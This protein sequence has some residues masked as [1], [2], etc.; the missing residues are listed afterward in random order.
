MNGNGPRIPEPRHHLEDRPGCR[1]WEP[2]MDAPP[3]L[4]GRYPGRLKRSREELEKEVETFVYMDDVSLGLREVT[5]YEVRTSVFLWLE[6]SD[7]IGIVV[8]PVKTV[9]LP[10]E[11]HAPTAEEIL[12]LGTVD[13]RITDGGGVTVANMKV[14]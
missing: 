6:L 11:G 5:A 4:S 2:G 12:L 10:P 9:A 7:N 14:Y 8:N 3:C 1:G 13:V